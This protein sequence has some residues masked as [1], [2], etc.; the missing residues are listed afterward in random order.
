MNNPDYTELD[1]QIVKVISEGC[2]R[3]AK[4]YAGL[5]ADTTR[6]YYERHVDRRLQALRRKNMVHFQSRTGWSVPK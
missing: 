5:P 6:K 2:N 3:F 1:E 4:I